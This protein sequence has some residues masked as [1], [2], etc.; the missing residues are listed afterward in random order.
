MSTN[1]TPTPLLNDIAP[2][3]NSFVLPDHKMVY[4]SV[5][6][7][8]CTSLRWMVADLSG[9][10][11]DRFIGT[12]GGQQSRLL[13]IHG[14]RARWQ[15]TPQLSDLTPDELAQIYP[16]DDWFAFT[17]VR[18]PYSRLW[19]AWESKFLVRHAKY[20]DLY[21]D[22][23]WFPRVASTPEQVLADWRTFVHARP[24]E[25]HPQLRKDV[26]FQNQV[27]SVRPDGVNYT[28]IYDLSMLPTLF[29]DIH[30]HLGPRGLDQPLYTPRANETPLPMT[31][32]VLDGGVRE[33][34]EDSF[35]DD[36]AA[37]GDRWSVEALTLADGWSE[38]AIEHAAYHTVANQRI[39]DLRT[40]ARR[41]QAEARRLR[42]ELE[43]TQRELDRATTTRHRFAG[44]LLTSAPVRT[45]AARPSVRRLLPD[46]AV[47]RARALARQHR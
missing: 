7:A 25:D 3:P 30:A 28:T 41:L 46:W 43:Q 12:I 11:P 35:A 18:D 33:V 26:H 47:A 42:T 38:D 23:P 37:F 5:T 40:G 4:M 2:P 17:V 9:E 15:R 32:E 24:W 10:D 45:V 8:A 22:D 21:A 39:G 27:R 14:D 36:F 19:S 29:E 16:H 31:P 34:I 20:V 6:K 1:A 13:G 44:R